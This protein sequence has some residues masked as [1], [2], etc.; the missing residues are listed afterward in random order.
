[1]LHFNCSS[2]TQ[3]DIV[4]ERYILTL[5][6]ITRQINEQQLLAM[7]ESW[8]EENWVRSKSGVDNGTYGGN[9][10]VLVSDAVHLDLFYGAENA[11]VMIEAT[12]FRG[13][14][15]LRP[16]QDKDQDC[17]M[18]DTTEELNGSVLHQDEDVMCDKN[19]FEKEYH[20][21]GMNQ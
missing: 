21:A 4:H 10:N 16:S 11:N 15:S 8:K 7:E 20:D 13:Q 3:N 1:M 14:D 19:G 5:P 12:E 2:I 6:H 17:G 9:V 18:E